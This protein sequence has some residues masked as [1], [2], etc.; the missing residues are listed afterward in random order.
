M[1]K[2]KKSIRRRDKK[3]ERKFSARAIITSSKLLKPDSK[4]KRELVEFSTST[5]KF[6]VT[7]KSNSAL[8]EKM[9]EQICSTFEVNSPAEAEVAAA[10]LDAFNNMD[11]SGLSEEAG[12]VLANAAAI[13]E[14]ALENAGYRMGK[15]G[16]DMRFKKNK[17]RFG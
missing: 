3:A 12:S 9:I 6:Q 5:D 15:N 1:G 17:E 4:T 10:Q 11:V 2:P 7:T 8:K 13:Y 14:T 16:P